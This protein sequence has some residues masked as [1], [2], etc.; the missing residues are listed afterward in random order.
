[1]PELGWRLSYPTV[2]AL[3]VIAGLLLWRGFKRAHWL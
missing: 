2:V 3:M 1:M